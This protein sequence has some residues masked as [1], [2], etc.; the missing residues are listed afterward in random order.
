M[1]TIWTLTYKGTVDTFAGWGFSD[2]IISRVSRD[3]SVLRAKAIVGDLIT[4]PI[5][6]YLELVTVSRNG[7]PYFVGSVVDPGHD[8]SGANVS[9]ALEL[10]DP[11]LWFKEMIFGQ[12]WKVFGY[13]GGATTETDTN[14]S[15]VFL[16]CDRAGAL[17]TAGDQIR[18]IVQ[19]AHDHGAPIQL[20]AD[21]VKVDMWLPIS[22]KQDITCAAALENCLVMRPDVV[23]WFDYSTS[24]YP[25]F[26]A[27]G[28]PDLPTAN[29][30]AADPTV[31]A[32]ALK[33]MRSQARSKVVVKFEQSNLFTVDGISQSRFS[34][35]EQTAG[36]PAQDEFSFGALLVTLPLGGSRSTGFTARLETVGCEAGGTYDYRTAA[37][38]EQF[39]PLFS[40]PRV[41]VSSIDNVSRGLPGT[42]ND[43]LLVTGNLHPW[44]ATGANPVTCVEDVFY[45]E[46]SYTEYNEDD[47]P[48]PIKTVDHA[49]FTVK[50]TVCNV[51]APGNTFAY[52]NTDQSAEPVPPGFAQSIYDALSLVYC[53]GNI[54]LVAQECGSQSW[55]GHRL[56]IV[57]GRP[58]WASAA[59]QVQSVRE[60][61][62]NGITELMIGP[63]KHVSPQ[64]IMDYLRL[65]QWRVVTNRPSMRNDGEMGGAGSMSMATQG[66]TENSSGTDGRTSYQ[67]FG[68]DIPQGGTHQAIV[69][70]DANVS[71]LQL[72]RQ[73]TGAVVPQVSAQA[74]AQGGDVQIRDSAGTLRVNISA[75]VQ[76]GTCAVWTRMPF[77]IPQADG[78]C[79]VEYRVVL[80]T[81][82][83]P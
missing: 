3:A 57:N 70:C 22:E 71:Q 25:T 61:L 45:A 64:Q 31:D 1:S 80:C 26:Y 19:W 72:T 35:I 2:P 23:T 13:S 10:Q 79:N 14:T 37:F 47:P 68:A 16:F 51:P 66:K 5:F 67:A 32:I 12:V 62:E 50:K 17:L 55:T 29:L 82:A 41:V 20:A 7:V 15:H 46:I 4:T 30:D 28:Q 42:G 11:Y 8:A 78:S 83:V 34:L 24:P 9:W 77:Y 59:A 76:P 39:C 18:A 36:D 27:W 38:W 69:T 63:P 40:K 56:S 54:R 53:A 48:K 43:Y 58:E 44:M 49:P 52:S 6:D 33:P 75:Y 21:S 73:T 74:S 65:L 81:E 60:D